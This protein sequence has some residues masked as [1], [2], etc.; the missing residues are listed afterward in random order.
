MLKDIVVV[1]VAVSFGV[2]VTV[3][4]GVTVTVSERV[5]VAVLTPDRDTLIA[6]DELRVL[7]LES[8]AEEV[9]PTLRLRDEAK[10][11]LFVRVMEEDWQEELIAPVAVTEPLGVGVCQMVRL[12]VMLRDN[13]LD[14]T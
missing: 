2:T 8:V 12:L 13:V 14:V 9:T 7:L 5:V 4:G 6:I 11:K 1:L 3:G 10:V